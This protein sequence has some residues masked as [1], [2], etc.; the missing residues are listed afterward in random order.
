MLAWYRSLESGIPNQ[1]STSSLDFDQNCCKVNGQYE[2]CD[3]N[4]EIPERSE[5]TYPGTA[6]EP[7]LDPSFFNSTNGTTQNW[8]YDTSPVVKMDAA[9]MDNGAAR[10]GAARNL[11]YV[12]LL[13]LLVLMPLVFLCLHFLAS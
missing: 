2:C 9:L 13:I 8:I 11:S 6:I 5:N 4:T 3:L 7:A 1:V 10:A 12:V